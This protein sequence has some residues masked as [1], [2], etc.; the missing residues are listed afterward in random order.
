MTHVDDILQITDNEEFVME[1][2]NHFIIKFK[3]VTFRPDAD[4][5]LG[6]TL[7]HSTDRK[8]ITLSQF[9]LIDGLLEKF[10]DNSS[11]L[12]VSSPAANDLFDV[13]NNSPRLDG[14]EGFLSII[15]T[16]M[17]LARLT[18]PDLLLPVTFLAS[19]T[20]CATQQD[21]QKLKRVLKYLLL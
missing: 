18:R 7:T 14:R 8:S 13:D 20:H 16:L 17:Y 19:R 5:Y 4:S 2:K 6:M 21:F 1:L 15:M 9:G 11:T 12:K 10:Q 3:T